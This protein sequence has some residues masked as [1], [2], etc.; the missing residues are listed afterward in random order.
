MNN[1]K[2]D[3]NFYLNGNVI[4]TEWF[5][6]E[7]NNLDLIPKGDMPGDKIKI[8][9]MHMK[10]AKVI[11][12]ELLKLLIPILEEAPKKKAVIAVHGG[13]G[14]GKSEI[15]S[16]ISHY[17]NLMNIGSYLLSGDNYPHRIP[18][19]NDAERIRIFRESGVKGLVSS[20]E[21]MAERNG[22]LQELQ[23]RDIDSDTDYQNKYPWLK[24]YQE[25]G[26]NGLK[27]YLSTEQ[28]IDFDELST[29]V[30]KF[31]NGE[32]VIYLKRM[33]REE[34]EL[35]YD[36]INFTNTN[37]M[38]IEWTHGNNNNL[39]GVDIPV[40]LNSTPQETLEHRRLRNRDG[41]TDSPFTMMVLNVEQDLLVSQ[42]SRAKLIVTRNGD[43]ISYEEF[44]KL[45][46]Q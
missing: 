24:I 19:V 35:W 1:I 25:A 15:G 31:I 34:K 46:G 43:I 44:Q 42:A 39:L 5:P 40:L 41:A 45:M 29:Y 8:D 16:L 18:K 20:G 6:P 33:G 36:P 32:P 2:Q 22:V 14:V 30:S 11:F 13:S 28:E 10:K 38:V 21:Y 27:K 26:C 4:R 23:E 17:L 7:I 9:E 12:P 37:V 3:L